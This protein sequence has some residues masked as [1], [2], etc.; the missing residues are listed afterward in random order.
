VREREG[1]GRP[2]A[3]CR[4]PLR[5]RVS[6]RRAAFTLFELVLILAIVVVLGA[7]IYPSID[8]MAGDYNLKAAAD[9]V[10]GGWAEAQSHAINEG[11]PYR[12]AVILDKGNF[13]IA[14][15][16]EDF[17]SGGSGDVP[18]GDPSTRPLV[19][20]DTLPKGVRFSSTN[21]SQGGSV[22]SGL[23]SSLPVGSTDGGAWTKVVTFLPDGTALEDVEVAFQARSTQP[24]VLRLRGLT[25]V[26]TLKT[27]SA[28]GNRP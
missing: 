15:D 22:D 9:M 13:R 5:R 16:S 3:T 18:D 20:E 10:R 21:A 1:G 24:L 27:T 23:D 19:L 7:L 17:W 6:A 25:G 28:E 12:F 2:R 14:P 11:R 26:A 8:A 4:P